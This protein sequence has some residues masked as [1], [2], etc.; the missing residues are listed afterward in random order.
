MAADDFDPSAQV[1]ETVTVHGAAWNGA[2]GAL[3]MVDGTPIYVGGLDTWPTGLEDRRVAVTGTLQAR[4]GQVPE[5]EDGDDDP[6]GLH[7]VPDETF[8]LAGAS[9]EPVGD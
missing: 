1:G 9:W 6:L 7:G 8:V 4:G 2:A 5:A 3:V